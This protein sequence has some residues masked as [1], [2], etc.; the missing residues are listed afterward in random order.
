MIAELVP[1]LKKMTRE[2]KLQLVD[3]LQE[4]LLSDEEDVTMQEPLKSQI[5]AE[6]E[7]RRQ[8]YLDHPE[9]AMTLDEARRRMFAS[10]K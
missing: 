8:Y 9:S 5:L 1:V 4:E 2:Q 6:L 7:R 10:R 3:E